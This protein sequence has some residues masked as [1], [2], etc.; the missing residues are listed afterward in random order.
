MPKLRNVVA[1]IDDDLHVRKSLKAL[2]SAFGYAVELYASG[3]AFLRAAAL[4][5]AGRLIVDVELARE[6]GFDLVRRLRE[7][8]YNFPI[9]FITARCDQMTEQRARDAGCI[10]FLRK[11]FDAA[12]LIEAMVQSAP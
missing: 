12:Q 4:S 10:A 7:D 11:P 8:G 2:L 3:D 9:I 1:V 5:S 6:S